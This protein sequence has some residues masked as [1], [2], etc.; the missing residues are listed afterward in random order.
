MLGLKQLSQTLET[1]MKAV[2]VLLSKLT[3]QRTLARVSLVLIITLLLLMPACSQAPSATTKPVRA[4]IIDHLYNLQPNQAFISQVTEE[5]QAYGFE[6][7]L[8]QGD[9]VTVD[10]YRQLPSLGYQL[11]IF[12]AHSGFLITPQGETVYRTWL[13]TNEPYSAA[14]HVAQQITDQ[15]AQARISE[16]HPWVFAIGSKFVTRSMEGEFNNT[17]IIMMGCSTLQVD[18][19]GR[20][21]TK[22]GVSSYLGWNDSVDLGYVDEATISLIQNLCSGGLTI[23]RAVA[24]VM[25]EKGPDPRYHAVLR[26]RPSQTG[27]QT[28]GE[29]IQ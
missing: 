12:R 3:T 19:L 7:D 22:K 28:I 6:V 16:H 10:L 25:A 23:E 24:K 20:A 15:L 21:F 2:I 4:A 5:L 26:Y 14:K 8:Y 17:V 27:E 13:F 11:I 9:E 1:L 18:D 29:L